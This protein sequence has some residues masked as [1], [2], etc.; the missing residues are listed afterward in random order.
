MS[1]P[2][3]GVPADL[4][5]YAFRYALGRRTGA[6]ADVARVLVCHGVVLPAWQRDQITKEITLAIKHQTAGAPCDVDE[7]MKVLR[8]FAELRDL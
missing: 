6:P 1:G 2:E 8:A 4:L 5:V 3:V 7:W